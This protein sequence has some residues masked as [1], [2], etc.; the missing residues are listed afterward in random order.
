MI[1]PRPAAQVGS[2]PLR[3]AADAGGGAIPTNRRAPRGD[4]WGC[5][6]ARLDAAGAEGPRPPGARAPRVRPGQPARICRHPRSRAVRAPSP[7]LGGSAREGRQRPPLARPRPERPAFPRLPPPPEGPAVSPAG[8][9]GGV[10][11]RAPGRPARGMSQS[12]QRFVLK[13]IRPRSRSRAGA[14]SKAREQPQSV[15]K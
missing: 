12:R 11:R 8:G 9:V 13:E 5:R 14:D 10:G 7:G 2:R 6:V 3:G 1:A 4:L 15:A